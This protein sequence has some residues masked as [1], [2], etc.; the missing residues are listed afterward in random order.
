MDKPPRKRETETDN[1][2]RP[3]Q[4]G[5]P[6]RGRALTAPR[7]AS[8][9]GACEFRNLFSPRACKGQ[10]LDRP[11]TVDDPGVGTQRRRINGRGKTPIT[12][13]A[14]ETRIV[15]PS[16]IRGSFFS[17][18]R[19]SATWE[20]EHA[21]APKANLL[22]CATSAV[23]QPALPPRKLTG[24]NRRWRRE[25]AGIKGFRI[26]PRLRWR[27]HSGGSRLLKRCRKSS[28]WMIRLCVACAEAWQS[29][30]RAQHVHRSDGTK[31][32]A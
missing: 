31:Q 3:V 26:T 10:G 28:A 18:L 2:P 17:T 7:R 15:C 9:E 14:M 5:K 24:S 27:A 8:C 16:P 19:L 21:A 22:R 25:Q 32:R 1:S 23:W 11:G 13:K 29:H 30:R 20:R 6:C 4:P 12:S